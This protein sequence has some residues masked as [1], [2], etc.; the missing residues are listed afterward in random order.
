[1]LSPILTALPFLVAY[2]LI[3]E[4]FVQIMLAIFA[5]GPTLASLFTRIPQ[6][7]WIYW[8]WL[9]SYLGPLATIIAYEIVKYKFGHVL[10]QTLQDPTFWAETV[11]EIFC[12]IVVLGDLLFAN[13]WIKSSATEKNGKQKY[14]LS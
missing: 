4:T 14:Y 10:L 2:Q 9:I 8:A 7:L 1:M 3:G 11:A 13:I 6:P 12:G 5:V